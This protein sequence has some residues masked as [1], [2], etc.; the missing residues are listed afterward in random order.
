MRSGDNVNDTL[1]N[2]KTYEIQLHRELIN[3]CRKYTNTLSIVSILG[4]LDIV[5]QETIELEH[6]TKN[7]Q[8]QHVGS[9]Q[10]ISDI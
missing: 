2:Y 7:T 3:S 10:D 1:K 4:I 8:N 6:A 5:K 9:E